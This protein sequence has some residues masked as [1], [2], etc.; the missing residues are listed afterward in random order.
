[1]L[2]VIMFSRLCLL[3]SALILLACPVFGQT[4]SGN[5]QGTVTDSTAAVLPGVS[6]TAL[7]LDTG[8]TRTV[9]TLG[10]GAYRLVALPLGRYELKFELQGFKPVTIGGVVLTIG[11]TAVHDAVLGTAVATESVTVTGES[12]LINA[13]S[14]HV[15]KTV[16]PEEVQNLPLNGRQFANLAVLVPGISLGVNPDPTHINSSAAQIG[17]SRGRFSNITVDGGDDNDDVVG[18]QLQGYSL[19]AIQEFQIISQQFK[20]EYGRASQGV[21]NVATKSGS[22]NLGG[23]FVTLFRDKALNSTTESEQ[24]VDAPKAAYRRVQLAGSFGGPIVRDRAFF[25]VAAERLA[26]DRELLVNTFGLAPE[27]DGNQPLPLRDGTQLVKVNW[28]A[29]ANHLL[30]F[31]YGHQTQADVF[32]AA[33]TSPPSDWADNKNTFHSALASIKSVLGNS[34]LNEFVVQWNSFANNIVGRVGGPSYIYPGGTTIGPGNSVPQTTFEKKVHLR[35]D[36]SWMAT[37]RGTHTLKT[38]INLVIEPTANGTFTTQTTPQYTFL[39]DRRDSP[40]DSIFYFI[41][42]GSFDMGTQH[43]LGLYFQDDWQ[44]RSN[45]TLNLGLRY[46]YYGGIAYDQSPNPTYQFIRAQRPEFDRPFKDPTKNIQPRVGLAWASADRQIAV[47]AGYGYFIDR[48]ILTTWYGM[49]AASR[50]PYRLG[51]FVYDG[52][53][54][55]RPD[56]SFLTVNDPLPPNQ[57]DP[58]KLP[59]PDAF[60]DPNQINP[61]NHHISGGVSYEIARST[62]LDVDFVYVAGRHTGSKDYINRFPAPGQPRPYAAAGYDFP[63]QVEQTEGHSLYRALNVAV[64]R[65]AGPVR[66][67]LWY[68]L[69]SG[70]ATDVRGTDE[71]L[72]SYPVREGGINDTTQFGP[73]TQD[74]THRFVLS[75]IFRVPGDVQVTA[76]ARYMSARPVNIRAGQDLNGDGINNDLPIGAK[77]I[78]DARGHYFFQADVRVSKFFPVTKKMR[79]EG[80]VQIFNLFNNLNPFSYMG[81]QTSSIYLQPRSFA[82][83]LP[84]VAGFEQ[85]LAEIGVRLQF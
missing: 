41:G 26:Q 61:R 69:S 44:V 37:G 78:N 9:P 71:V 12:P 6:V 72:V 19:E 34:K 63:I 22:N 20:A 59:T 53:G 2:E 65:V 4:P 42:D 16:E 73:T 64:R 5:I 32:G 68:T 39:Y 74:A 76:L 28:Q 54:L 80:F 51:Y 62:S 3:L 38:G 55:K 18:G 29:S 21:V 23:S 75:G 14:A 25:F 60:D 84:S 30:M 17:G 11:A 31:R 45:L 48:P 46:D 52:A 81:T 27:E 58:A 47:R 70:W 36:F 82:G 49:L 43:I 13:V 24:R 79:V 77:H 1:L 67:D 15:E 50:D 7:N 83:D 10:T 56:A 85:R 8:Y 35:D 66:L 33:T 57:I 40:I